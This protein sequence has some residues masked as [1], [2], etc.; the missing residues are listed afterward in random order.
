ML[1][2]GCFVYAEGQLISKFTEYQ[3]MIALCLL[4]LI[5]NI[6][7]LDNGLGKTP[8]MG[9]NPWNKYGCNISEAIVR[10]TVDSLINSGLAAAGY[11]YINLDDCWQSGRDPKTLE[12]IADPDRFPSG[13]PALVQYVHSKGLKFG[14]YSDAVLVLF[15]P[16]RELPLAQADQDRWATKR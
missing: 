8:P 16:L 15:D 1:L 13:I 9:W 10:D 11:V 5:L 12:I 3:F 2:V 4:Y 6:F 14:L 7:A